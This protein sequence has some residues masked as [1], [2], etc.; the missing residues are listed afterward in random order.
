MFGILRRWNLSALPVKRGFLY[1]EFLGALGVLLWLLFP[2]SG[3]AHSGFLDK[4]GCHNNNKKHVYECHDGLLKGQTFKSQ[5][6]ALKAL[7]KKKKEVAAS[8]N[9]TSPSTPK[10]QTTQKQKPADGK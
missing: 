5:A 9:K 10:V 3:V 8:G 2:A 6:E 4:N 7:E 1:G